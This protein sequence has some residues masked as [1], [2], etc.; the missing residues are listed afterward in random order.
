MNEIQC[1]QMNHHIA[2]AIDL[3]DGPAAL[4]RKLRVT[5]QAVCFW[6]D[7]KRKFPEALGA[8]LEG[9]T[10]GSVTRRDLWPDTYLD[11]WPELG[12][13]STAV[14]GGTANA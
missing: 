13:G 5:T 9:I 11:I 6:R 10:G 2:R 8:R 1:S 3:S 4:A 7:G 12:S 14:Q